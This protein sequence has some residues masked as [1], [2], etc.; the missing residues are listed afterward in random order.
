[1]SGLLDKA[2]ADFLWRFL[3]SF[4]LLYAAAHAIDA[5][6]PWALA[7]LKTAIAQAEVFFLNTIGISASQQ[8]IVVDA[9]GLLFAMALE[10][11]GIVLAI[12]L[13]CLFYATKKSERKATPEKIAASLL[14]LLAFNLLRVLATI[15]IAVNFG[16]TA[17]EITHALLWVVDSLAVLLVWVWLVQYKL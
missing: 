15:F 3:F 9:A 5:L 1:M 8:G 17:F 12:L 10:C 7:P 6:A 13:F 4:F 2:E 14:L 11:T 16:N